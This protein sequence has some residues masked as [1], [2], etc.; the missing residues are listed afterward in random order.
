[1]RRR[2]PALISVSLVALWAC[3]WLAET[4]WEPAWKH[5]QAWV[6]PP[7][8]T[9]PSSR[10]GFPLTPSR[11]SPTKPKDPGLL[12]L[13]VPPIPPQPPLLQEALAQ[14]LQ[15]LDEQ[16]AQAETQLHPLP[17]HIA[18]LPNLRVI[19]ELSSKG[20]AQALTKR[21]QGNKAWVLCL[22]FRSVDPLPTLGQKKQPGLWVYL[23]SWIPLLRVDRNQALPQVPRPGFFPRTL[24]L[25]FRGGAP[26]ETK[27]WTRFER[28]L[29]QCQKIAKKVGCKLIPLYIP[30]AFETNG[31]ILTSL[32]SDLH[33]D[34]KQFETG[35]PSRRFRDLCRR[36]GL[37]V[38][39]TVTALR[40]VPDKKS[41]P[42]Y[43]QVD[44]DTK[45]RPL[46]TIRGLR[47][48]LRPLLPKLQAALKSQ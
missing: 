29:A 12:F 27:L 42:L 48:L 8:R 1:M 5:A 38:V 43:L 35:R 24:Q 3:L 28:V 31:A 23:R 30:Q 15:S 19:Y 10:R 16:R 2:F 40:R 39:A 7:Q 18:W 14:G 25:F 21:L 11:P 44:R 17:I 22:S 32:L 4:I 45:A 46:L 20:H 41:R 34:P 36:L 6:L 37:P 33:L 26:G 47:L 9:A 13:G